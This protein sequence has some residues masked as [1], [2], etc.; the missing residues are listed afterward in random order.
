MNTFSYNVL[1]ILALGYV[2][3]LCGSGRLN[4]IFVHS[5]FSTEGYNRVR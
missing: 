1:F 2:W 4:D 3:G 5:D